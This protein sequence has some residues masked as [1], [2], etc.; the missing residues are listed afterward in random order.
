MSPGRSERPMAFRT[1]INYKV[2][3]IEEQ[4]KEYFFR[5][6]RLATGIAVLH[7]S[8]VIFFSTDDQTGNEQR[9]RLHRTLA[10]E[11]GIWLEDE[12]EEDLDPIIAPPPLPPPNNPDSRKHQSSHNV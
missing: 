10:P 3:A 1:R 12:D 11:R 6:I 8:V 2:K 4:H 7:S 5:T 9:H